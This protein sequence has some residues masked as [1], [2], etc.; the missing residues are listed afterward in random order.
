MSMNLYMQMRIQLGTM[1][2]PE[3]PNTRDFIMTIDHLH[4]VQESL[5]L[6]VVP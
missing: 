2:T 3:Q 4:R 1:R 5:G 6:A